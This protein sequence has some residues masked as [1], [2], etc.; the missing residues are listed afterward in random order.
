MKIL[1]HTCCA[2]CLIYPAK[3]LKNDGHSVTGFFYNP[4]IAPPGEYKKRRMALVGFTA[5]NN[6]ATEV[7]Y[8]EY[9]PSQFSHAIKDNTEKPGRCSMCFSLRLNRTAQF[10]KEKGFDAFSTTLLVSPYQDQEL[11]KSN[12]EQI[13][14]EQGI[15]FHYEDFRPGFSQ[16]HKQAKDEQIYCQNYCGCFYSIKASP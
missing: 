8:P 6:A 9:I 13:A 2:P 4:N 1:L 14:R 15:T 3:K 16:A 11:I 12:G 7:I 5:G 10:A